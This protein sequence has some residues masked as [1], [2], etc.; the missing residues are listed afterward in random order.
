MRLLSVAVFSSVF[1][2]KVLRLDVGAVVGVVLLV[3]FV[4]SVLMVFVGRLVLGFVVVVL[5]AVVCL[6]LCVG[7]GGLCFTISVVKAVYTATS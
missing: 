2:V 5:G 1:C 6:V 3:M 7:L 4:L